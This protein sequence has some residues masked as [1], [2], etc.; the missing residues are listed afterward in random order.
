MSII[1]AGDQ[2]YDVV[3]AAVPNSFMSAKKD[4][5]K[6]T[7]GSI[8]LAKK[9]QLTRSPTKTANNVRQRGTTR[10]VSSAAK[11]SVGRSRSRN[12]Y[13]SDYD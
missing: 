5:G 4:S 8:K 12:N 11:S 10:S 6:A 2:S 7:G 3:N 1:T 13:G 9:K